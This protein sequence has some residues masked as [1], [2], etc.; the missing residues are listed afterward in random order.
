MQLCFGTTPTT[1]IPTFLTDDFGDELCVIPGEHCRVGEN[2]FEL[3]IIDS[4][5]WERLIYAG[6]RIDD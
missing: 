6:L 2:E 5:S 3:R 1:T 4:R